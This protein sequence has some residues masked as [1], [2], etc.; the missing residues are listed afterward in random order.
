M[1]NSKTDINQD[2]ETDMPS[3]SSQPSGGGLGSSSAIGKR[4][5]AYYEDVASEPVPDRF[6]SLLDAL[7]N[8]E[9]KSRG[10]S[11]S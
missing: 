2:A 6:L 5:K 7:D 1:T 11:Q 10:R 8:A 4:L 3:T 9:M